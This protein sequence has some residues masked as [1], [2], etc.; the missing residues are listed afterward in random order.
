MTRRDL[1]KGL[2]GTLAVSALAPLAR[3]V[4]RAKSPV[5]LRA[6]YGFEAEPIGPTS[7][8]IRIRLVRHDGSTVLKTAVGP[9]A[10][11][12]YSCLPSAAIALQPGESCW[13]EWDGCAALR[14]RLFFQASDG[15]SV[16]SD[17]S[18]LSRLTA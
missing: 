12:V 11:C 8:V 9:D 6:L 2:F 4:P 18:R 1:F 5:T 7:D 14:T 13:L 17:G 15:S 10:R 16:V 3:S